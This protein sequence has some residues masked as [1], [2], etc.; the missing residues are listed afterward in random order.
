MASWYDFAKEIF[1]LAGNSDVTVHPISTAQYPTPARR[2]HYSVLAKDKIKSVF[3][4]D[5]PYWRD[6]L[7]TCINNL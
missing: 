3:G 5:I 4:I 2:P 7:N 6:S 1:H